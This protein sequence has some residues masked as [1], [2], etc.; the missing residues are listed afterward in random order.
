MLENFTPTNRPDNRF[1]FLD[2]DTEDEIVAG[3]T[4]VQMF[5]LPFK[6]S[7][8][9]NFAD[10]LYTQGFEPL[11]QKCCCSLEIIE[12]DNNSSVV[13]SVLYPGESLAFTDTLLDSFVQLKLTLKDGRVVYSIP[14]R[15]KIR[16]PLEYRDINRRND[17]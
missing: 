14:R 13:K 15:L 5:H 16:I 6:Y 2:I 4:C 8:V 17:D 10:I 9:V 12:E 1:A 3:E 7:E 11:I